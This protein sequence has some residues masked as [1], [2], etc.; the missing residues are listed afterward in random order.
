MYPTEE[1]GSDQG[2]NAYNRLYSKNF[3]V[4]GHEVCAT[5]SKL[6][7]PETFFRIRDILMNSAFTI[8]ESGN[9]G[10]NEDVHLDNSTSHTKIPLS[11]DERSTEQ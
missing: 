9:C 6:P 2:G 7:M 11:E 3:Q 1:S 8:A 4:D 5:F 10:Y